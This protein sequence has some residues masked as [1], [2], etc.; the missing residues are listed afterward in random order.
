MEFKNR[1]VSAFYLVFIGLGLILIGTGCS[2]DK[3]DE[4][5]DS[6]TIILAHAMNLTH[7][8][9]I[10]MDQM[11]ENV[12]RV[13]DGKLNIKTYPN[14]QL[15]SER[16]LL[17]LVQVGTVGMTKVSAGALETIVPAM[18]VFSVPYLFRDE[19]HM[20][21][22]L[23][24]DLG[25]ELLAEGDAYRLKGIAYYDAGSRSL[26]T[27]NRRVETPEDLKGMKVRV[28]PSA[29]ATELVKTLGASPTPLTYGELY[30]AFQGGIIDAAE[31]N[32]PSFY[33][34]RHYEVCDYYILN[35]HTTIPD[36]MVI[37]TKL[38]ESLTEEEQQ[39]LK[40][41]VD[42]SVDFQREL[43]KESVEESYEEVEAAGVEIIRPD[44][45]PFR[46]HLQPLY[47]E[48]EQNDPDLY[49]WIER[50]EEVE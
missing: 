4:N 36:V 13:S 12:E 16:E 20:E 24:G 23:W 5:S 22:V 8:V 42:E 38:W 6:K 19:A 37:G 31:N 25:E 26:Y 40:Q 46:E 30:T 47:D 45:E 9:S 14:S 33:T 32:P 39:W 28:M 2:S 48:Y 3:G 41:A 18:K 49:K 44:K 7:P 35:E 10:A 21:Q 1:L 15:G 50:I 11:A 27:K 17:E 43:W 34:S 29:M